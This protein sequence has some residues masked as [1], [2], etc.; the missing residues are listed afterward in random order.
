MSDATSFLR[1]F[2]FEG[3][4]TGRTCTR[5]IDGDRIARIILSESNGETYPTQ[6][7]YVSLEVE[8]I[9]TKVGRIDK[10]L[11]VFDQILNTNQ[12]EDD[13]KDYPIKGNRTF[14]VLTCC[15]WRWY[16]AVPKDIKP[17]VE[18]VEKYIGMFV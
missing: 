15:G 12:R 10:A 8:I 17:L 18:A 13:R 9:G 16:I 4:Y 11:F 1:T 5:K 7:H 6:G 2:G 3:E 14:Q